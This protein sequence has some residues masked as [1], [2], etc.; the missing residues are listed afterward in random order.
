MGPKLTKIHHE[1]PLHWGAHPSWTDWNIKNNAQSQKY[2][3][4]MA[5][6]CNIKRNGS[7]YV[8]I[9]FSQ[10]GNMTLGMEMRVRQSTITVQAEISIR[11]WVCLFDGMTRNFV[12]IFMIKSTKPNEFGD[13]LTY[14]SVYPVL[15]F[16]ITTNDISQ[17]HPFFLFRAIYRMLVC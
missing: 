6:S 7:C 17:P 13:L 2:I 5:Y 9:F 15:R 12:Q 10:A 14:F 3:A 1:L 4:H 11:F 16:M 8:S